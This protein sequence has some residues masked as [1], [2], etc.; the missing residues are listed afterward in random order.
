M[1]HLSGVADVQILL[2]IVY[3]LIRLQ[4]SINK[5]VNIRFK[6]FLGGPIAP[7]CLVAAR[8]WVEHIYISKLARKTFFHFLSHHLFKVVDILLFLHLSSKILHKNLICF[9]KGSES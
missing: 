3:I 9:L 7:N 6:I 1:I 8:R 4:K 2:L 5:R